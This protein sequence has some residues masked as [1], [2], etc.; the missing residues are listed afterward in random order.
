ML[1][2]TNPRG[3]PE[4]EEMNIVQKLL[5]GSAEIDRMMSEIDQIVALLI[6]YLSKVEEVMPTRTKVFDR[7]GHKFN[8]GDE[9]WMVGRIA[10]CG[11]V[12]IELEVSPWS[13]LRTV[14]YSEWGKQHTVESYHVKGIHDALPR[15]VEALAKRYPSLSEAWQPLLKAAE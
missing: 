15:L 12:F 14:Y 4:M 13:G 1:K 8:H 5:K 6:G 11:R 2:F 9:T 10:D 7:S 3:V